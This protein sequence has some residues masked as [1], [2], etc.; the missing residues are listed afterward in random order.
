MQMQ[1]VAY[2]PTWMRFYER[3]QAFG[4]FGALAKLDSAPQMLEPQAAAVLENLFNAIATAQPQVL[5]DH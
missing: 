2:A 1:S 4:A 3:A 5:A